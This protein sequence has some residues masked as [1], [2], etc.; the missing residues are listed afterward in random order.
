MM[1]EIDKLDNLGPFLNVTAWA[2]GKHTCQCETRCEY[3]PIRLKSAS[4]LHT[5]SHRHVSFLVAPLVSK[6]IKGW[7]LH[8]AVAYG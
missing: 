8:R 2:F 5:V 3:I 1:L 7:H 4:M 6:R